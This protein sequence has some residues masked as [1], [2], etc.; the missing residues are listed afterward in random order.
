MGSAAPAP[1]EA[2]PRVAV[3]RGVRA[4]VVRAV[5]GDRPVLATMG[6]A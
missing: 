4:G 5:P 1:R 3:E 2:R 6:P